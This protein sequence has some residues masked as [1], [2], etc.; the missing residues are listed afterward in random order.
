[1][2]TGGGGNIEGKLYVFQ[3]ISRNPKSTGRSRD[4]AWDKR[5][6]P[7]LKKTLCSSRHVDCN[8]D[9]DALPT[10]MRATLLGWVHGIQVA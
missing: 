8:V 10:H 1:M 9:A 2:S 4:S 3:I 6:Y 5:R 7:K